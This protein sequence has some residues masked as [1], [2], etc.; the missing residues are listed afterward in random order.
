MIVM[1]L[2]QDQTSH[3]DGQRQK[4]CQPKPKCGWSAQH[5][6]PTNRS[7]YGRSLQLM[8]RCTGSRNSLLTAEAKALGDVV[9]QALSGVAE[10]SDKT[11]RQPAFECVGL[12][13]TG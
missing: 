2:N 7:K 1:L 12:L 9:R 8:L 10:F 6:C 11:Q 4:R 3:Q 13:G 5:G